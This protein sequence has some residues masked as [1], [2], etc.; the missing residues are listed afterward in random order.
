M[1]FLEDEDG[2]NRKRLGED[3]NLSLLILR[4]TRYSFYTVAKICRYYEQIHVIVIRPEKEKKE[5]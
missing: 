5:T 1:L 2:S 3:P 4:N